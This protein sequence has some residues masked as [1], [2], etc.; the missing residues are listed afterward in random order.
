MNRNRKT[1]VRCCILCVFLSFS[2][3][4]QYEPPEIENIQSMGPYPGSKILGNGTFCFSASGNPRNEEDSP[5]IQALY[6]RD[7]TRNFLKS[8]RFEFDGLDDPQWISSAS[9]PYFAETSQWK[10][11][12]VN[13]VTRLYTLADPAKKVIVWE[14]RLVNTSRRKTS[15]KIKPVF[16]FAR[17]SAADYGRDKVQY[18]VDEFVFT[19][20]FT[21]ARPSDVKEKSLERRVKLAPSESYKFRFLVVISEDQISGIQT[22]DTLTVKNMRRVA[23][24][25][26]EAWLAEGEEP[27]FE[28]RKDSLR[29]R[30]NLISVK[31]LNLNGAVPADVTGQF[32]TND[33]PQ[34]YPRDAFM[35]A[36]MFLETGHLAEVKQ[37][38]DFWGN[39]PMKSIGEWYARY[40]A[41]GRATEGGTGARY[42]VPEWD[43]NGYY[44]SL[45]YETFLRYGIW[46]GDFN[47]I[48]NLLTFI[49]L[50]LDQDG[51]VEEGG[52]I[53]WP[54]KLPSSNM[55][56]S[57]A[58]K[59]AAFMAKWRNEKQLSR[60]WLAVSERMDKG[61]STLFDPQDKTYKDLRNQEFTWNTSAAFGWIWGYDDHL[62][63]RLSMEYW[64]NHCRQDGDGIQY[65]DGEGYGDDL[66]GFT[67]GALAR[68]YA[69]KHRTDRYLRLKKWFDVNCNF[70]GLMPERI[71]YPEDEEKISEASPLTWCSAEYVMVLLEG[72]RHLILS[73]DIDNA[74]K[75]AVRLCQKAVAAQ[76]PL[77]DTLTRD[78][79]INYLKD[80]SF[81][82]DNFAWQKERILSLFGAAYL[83]QK[84]ISLTMHTYPLELISSNAFDIP[85]KL[86]MGENPD[87]I[88]VNSRHESR[89]WRIKTPRVTESGTHSVRV[90]PDIPFPVDDHFGYFL[91]EWLF[92]TDD[93]TFP[94]HFPVH[95]Q[96]LS[97]YRITLK[98]SLVTKNLSFRMKN[99]SKV[100]AKVRVMN[101]TLHDFQTFAPD[102]DGDFYISLPDS[103]SGRDTTAL[104]VKYGKYET[105]HTFSWIHCMELDLTDR[106][107]FSPGQAVDQC[108]RL[109]WD[110][111]LWNPIRVPALWEDE[112]YPDLD[113]TFWYRRFFSLPDSLKNRQIWLEIGAIDDEDETYI[114]CTKVGNTAGWN[115]LRRYVISP[116]VIDIRWNQSNVI[117][118]K[119]T[120]YGKGGGIHKGPVRFLIEK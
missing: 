90:F 50:R 104:M 36:R 38:M 111:S 14:G 57:A 63:L 19:A 11:G 71:H 66:F 8:L 107:E 110:D 120:D 22:W 119:V 93:L 45:V 105:I 24:R 83:K 81:W 7:Y 4:C 116:G 69:A 3:A 20:G 30:S 84:D 5:G 100:P 109:R 25:E 82:R 70:Y 21:D 12:P 85:F 32:V 35:T 58:F 49:E 13:I 112:G 6:I 103:G 39:V 88:Q 55:S 47:R 41:H 118:V 73:D 68:Y 113:G 33:L 95:Y 74:E 44:T 48:K 31:A 29:F 92:R 91:L 94:I 51:L 52:I 34:L 60:R 28:S 96:I 64:W 18:L 62:R 114:N 115:L 16:E 106:W 98:D 17:P 75:T 87:H 9:D 108:F 65:F 72:S 89:G 78:E 67:T 10:A 46:L 80:A 59:Q 40:D 23:D 99:R 102:F 1:L 2:S 101:D 53:E 86:K 27:S 76:I 79:C 61:L 117:Q 56:L 42:D 26:W 97:P 37:I 15:F 54:A 77:N 43:N